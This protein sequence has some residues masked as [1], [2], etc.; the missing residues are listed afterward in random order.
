VD[1]TDAIAVVGSCGPERR[2]Y[3]QQLARLTGRALIPASRLAGSPHPAQEAAV[4]ASWT[5]T[6]PGVVVELPD[7]VPL[8][9]LIGAFADPDEHVRLRG[10][11]CVVDAAHVLDDLHRDDHLPLRDAGSGVAAPL[12]ARSLLTALQIEYAS[13][14]VPVNWSGMPSAELATVMALLSH[15]SPGARLRLRP[16]VVEDLDGEAYSADQ[17][18]PGW[19]R[20]MNG[21]FDPHMTDRRVSALRYEQIRPLHPERLGRLLDRIAEEE[22]GRVVRSAGFCRLATRPD[23]VGRWEHAGRAIA[24]TPLAADGRLDEDE[25]LLALGQDLAIIGIDLDAGS[26]MAAL[27]EAAVDD[28]EFAAG[29]SAWHLFPDPFPVWTAASE[30]GD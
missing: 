8:P 2:A 24:L 20:L 15:L 5:A 13:T 6:G 18:R 7:E 11:V 27:D 12:I 22:F 4:L 26:L 30:H 23:T 3:A 25:E 19:V 9:E 10:V 16:D 21:C 1:D 29:A 14:I 17:E 28:G